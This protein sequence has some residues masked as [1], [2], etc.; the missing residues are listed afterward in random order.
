MDWYSLLQ[1]S[2]TVSKQNNFTSE[3]VHYNIWHHFGEKSPSLS[4]VP[5]I[6]RISLIVQEILKRPLRYFSNLPAYVG[7]S[8]SGAGKFPTKTEI[9]LYM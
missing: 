4:K 6:F 7:K 9:F 2:K 8:E 5:E 3:G 1:E